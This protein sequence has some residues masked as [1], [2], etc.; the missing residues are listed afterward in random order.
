[1]NTITILLLLICLSVLI[2]FLL[3]SFIRGAPD[4][5]PEDEFED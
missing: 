2:G 1:M 4:P 3:G 5:H